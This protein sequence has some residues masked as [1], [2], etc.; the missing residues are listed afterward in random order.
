MKEFKQELEGFTFDV[1]I[2]NHIENGTSTSLKLYLNIDFAD[3]TDKFK[4]LIDMTSTLD[5][6]AKVDDI[7]AP[8]NA[9]DIFSKIYGI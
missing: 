2:T 5:P 7:E 8:E 3:D 6:N 4:M 9:V 1:D